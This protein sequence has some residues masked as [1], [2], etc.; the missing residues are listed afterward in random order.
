MA[1]PTKEVERAA[2]TKRQV[3]K[4]R[5]EAG[6]GFTT[7]NKAKGSTQRG[8]TP[9]RGQGSVTGT[10]TI[11]RNTGKIT[12]SKGVRNPDSPENQK[13]RMKKYAADSKKAAR[14]ASNATAKTAASNTA[15]STARGA[16]G[17]ALGKAAGKLIPG[18]GTAVGAAEGA[19]MASDAMGLEGGK[20]VGKRTR[21][22]NVS[23]RK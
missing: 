23:K 5:I 2:K 20:A 18:I 11:D 1:S 14:A 19:K 7:S 21:Q 4:A 6:K 12:K 16:L 17:K 3:Q 10:R 8:A 15:K 22:G 13:T 9:T